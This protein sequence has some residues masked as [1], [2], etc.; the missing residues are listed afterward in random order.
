MPAAPHPPAEAER[1]P[2]ERSEAPGVGAMEHCHTGVEVGK[3]A[4]VGVG[5]AAS[6]PIRPAV[7]VGGRPRA[8]STHSQWPIDLDTPARGNRAPSAEAALQPLHVRTQPQRPIIEGFH[9]LRLG[10]RCGR[11]RSRWIRCRCVAHRGLPACRL[12]NHD[13]NRRL[14]LRHLGLYVREM[15]DSGVVGPLE[16]VRCCRDTECDD[17]RG[18]QKHVAVRGNARR[19]TPCGG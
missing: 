3:A 12:I 13:S 1:S 2:V 17:D 19:A 4:P 10:R 15:D 6:I 14:V 5:P 7:T 8:R 16:D 11:R 9:K 18:Q